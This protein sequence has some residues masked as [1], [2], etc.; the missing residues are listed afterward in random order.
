VVRPPPAARGS[1]HVQTG[2][3]RG[4]AGTS[5]VG[6]RP[7]G[8]GEGR[9]AGRPAGG[10]HHAKRW[11]RPTKLSPCWRGPFSIVAVD[12]LT[13]RAT[14]RDPTDLL[15]MKPD[16]HWSQ[17]RQYRMGLTSE[18]DLLDLR[19]MD[20]AE[21]LIVRFVRHEMHYPKKFLGKVATSSPE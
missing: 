9:P 13:Q 19:A 17:L 7:V 20:T 5:A 12:E 18:A 16:V 21:D 4:A 15:I 10:G 1:N 14:L 3:L 2:Y 8:G 11:T 6:G